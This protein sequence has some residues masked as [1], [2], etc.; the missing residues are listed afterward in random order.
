MTRNSDS[1]LDEQPL[2]PNHLLHLRP[3]PS[4]PPGV[5]YKH[6]LYIKRAWRQAQYMADLFWR[7]WTKENLPTLLERQKWNSVKRNLR[8]GDIVL[9]ADDDF[10]SR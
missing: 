5:F 9:V 8:V 6:D 2:T 10:T 7:R 3:S 4:L 1:P